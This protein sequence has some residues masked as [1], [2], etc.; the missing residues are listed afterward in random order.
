MSKKKENII[1]IRI[2]IT[3]VIGLVNFSKYLYVEIFSQRLRSF[4][5]ILNI[6]KE[7][8]ALGFHFV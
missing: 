8:V 3:K 4:R 5:I 2:L 7:K 6:L 1:V